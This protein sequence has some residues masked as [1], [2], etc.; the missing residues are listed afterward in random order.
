MPDIMEK[1]QPTRRKMVMFFL[2]DASNSMNEY[3]KIDSLNETM[4]DCIDYARDL[5]A[6]QSDVDINI[7]VLSFGVGDNGTKCE[8]MCGEPEPVDRFVWKDIAASGW[9]P[10]ASALDM[11][12]SV[13]SRKKF[14][15]T[16]S[17][18]YAPVI[19]V[20]SDGIPIMPSEIGGGGYDDSQN[21]LEAIEKLKKNAWFNE[22]IRVAISIGDDANK[23]LL[24]KITGSDKTVLECYSK[25][26]LNKIIEFI[27]LTSSMISSTIVKESNNAPF[28]PQER[29]EQELEN[30]KE[31]SE[32]ELVGSSG[33]STE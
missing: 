23:P 33:W 10:L 26:R 30:N 18:S 19:T 11:L 17:A 13:M 16:P 1:E 29:M 14:L 21:V 9:T 22:S 20:I 7:A 27:M 6:K 25:E 8:W 32:E 24:E 15:D 12:N 5:D 31:L 2:L 3:G 4:L 28:K